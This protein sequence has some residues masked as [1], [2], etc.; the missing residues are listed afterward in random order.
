MAERAGL[1][2]ERGQGAGVR[3]QEEQRRKRAR[4]QGET[5]RG[6][7]G[8]AQR[9]G[10]EAT[11]RVPQ[12]RGHPGHLVFPSPMASLP[13]LIYWLPAWTLRRGP[14]EEGKV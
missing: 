6:R 4:K 5:A 2:R 13:L 12:H 3:G 14:G 7:D 8:G 11:P 9:G 10:G 1:R